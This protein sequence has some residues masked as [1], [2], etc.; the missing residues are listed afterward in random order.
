MVV[1]VTGKT[2]LPPVASVTMMLHVPALTA[3]IV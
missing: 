3:V 1:T 2:A